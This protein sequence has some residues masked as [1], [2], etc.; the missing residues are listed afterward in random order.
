MS[1]CGSSVLCKQRRLQQKIH[2]KWKM[3]VLNFELKVST[4]AEDSQVFL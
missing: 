1:V 2:S 3:W 4:D